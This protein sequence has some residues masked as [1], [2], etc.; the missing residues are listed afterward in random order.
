MIF[1]GNSI[2]GQ[3]DLL[4]TSN[5]YFT[6]GMIKLIFNHEKVGNPHENIDVI[7][8]KFLQNKCSQARFTTL[9]ICLL[10]EG[11]VGLKE[12]PGLFASYSRLV[13][14]I[15]LEFCFEPICG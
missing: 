8:M 9:L 3:V 14:L 1:N 12:I 5:I 6:L 7:K 13:L 2:L 10:Q 4:N 11:T 15:F